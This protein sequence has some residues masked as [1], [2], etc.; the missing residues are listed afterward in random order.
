MWGGRR[1]AALP[2]AVTVPRSS[3]R[4]GIPSPLSIYSPDGPL[5]SGSI[6]PGTPLL[7]GTISSEPARLAGLRARR[8]RQAKEEAKA[9]ETA[10]FL[11]GARNMPFQ[12]PPAGSSPRSPEFGLSREGFPNADPPRRGKGRKYYGV[13]VGRTIGVFDT[14][15][16]CQAVVTGIRA[17]EF[18]SFYSFSEARDYVMPGQNNRKI[19][20]MTFAQSAPALAPT[21]FHGRRALRATLRVLQEGETQAHEFMCCLDSGSDVNL[22]NRILLHDVHPV[23]FEEIAH[24][25]VET[26]FQEEGTLRVFLRGDV[27]EIPALAAVKEQLPH[28]CAVLLGVPGVDDLGVR[29]D[30][31]RAKRLK[32]LECNVGEKTLRTWLEANGAQKVAKVSFD[33]TEVDVNPELPDAIQTRVRGLLKQYEDVFAGLQDSLPKPF[34]ADPVELKFVDNPEP[35]RSKC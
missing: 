13:R 26:L 8:A 23:E 15:V 1:A 20:F 34:A 32:R 29:L 10:G 31:H 11:L 18:R 30:A 16:E 24:C 35:P 19:C 25:G 4:A 21:S 6:P 5:I 2:A 12:H 9:D 17:A 27:V 33:V 22:A 3:V 28:G 7:P 14:W